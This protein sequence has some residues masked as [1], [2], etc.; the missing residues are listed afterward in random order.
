MGQG[1]A[2]VC[3]VVGMIFGALFLNKWIEVNG[4]WLPKDEWHCTASHREGP[5]H[6]QVD[7]CDQYS[8]KPTAEK[9]KP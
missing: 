9:E 8:R 3:I 5:E 7:V 1:E 2:L 4:Y 6:S